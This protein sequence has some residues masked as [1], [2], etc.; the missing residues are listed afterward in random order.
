[1]ADGI[2]IESVYWL[3]GFLPLAGLLT[4]FLPRIEYRAGRKRT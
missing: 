4:L 2:G 3:C 1:L